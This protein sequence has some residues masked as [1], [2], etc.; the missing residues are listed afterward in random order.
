MPWAPA[1]ESFWSLASP[2]YKPSAIHGR[3]AGGQG[4]RERAA[5]DAARIVA[6]LLAHRS[7]RLWAPRRKSPARWPPAP[8]LAPE[9]RSHRCPH[10]TQHPRQGFAGGAAGRLTQVGTH[11]VDIGER[12]A[13]CEPAMRGRVFVF[14]SKRM[15]RVKLL[16]WDVSDMVAL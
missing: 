15:D 5:I 12:S 10:G 4:G 7:V 14:R 8:P 2:S 3:A 16:A 13:A 6:E 1:L 9:R 11:A